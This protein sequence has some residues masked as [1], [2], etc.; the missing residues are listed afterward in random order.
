[1]QNKG[2]LTIMKY[3]RACVGSFLVIYIY[4][5]VV[6]YY[7]S[8]L[9]YFWTRPFQFQIHLNICSRHIK[10]DDSFQTKKNSGWI[11]INLR[12]LPEYLL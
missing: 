1:M 9:I 7:E 10:A 6:K 2:K 11:R 5:F 12:A 4:I 3:F 8:C